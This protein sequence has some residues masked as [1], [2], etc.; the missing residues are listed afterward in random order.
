MVTLITAPKISQAQA[1]TEKAATEKTDAT[2]PEE[3]TGETTGG[4]K[5]VVDKN[6]K[7][8]D[9]ENSLVMAIKDGKVIIELRPD[10]APK[11]VARIKELTREG[12]YDGIVFHRVIESFMAQTGDPTGTGRGGSGKNLKAEFSSEKHVRGTLSMARAND[13]DSADSQ[14]FIVFQEAPHLDENYTVFGKVTEGMEFIDKIKKGYGPNGMVSE[15][16]KIISLKVAADIEYSDL[17]ES[18]KGSTTPDA[19]KTAGEQPVD[20]NLVGEKTETKT[21]PDGSI[22][23]IKTTIKKEE[24]QEAEKAQGTKELAPKTI[25][26][27]SGKPAS[28]Q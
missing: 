14:F 9:L 28:Q 15:P 24:L 8:K 18:L 25:D 27:N 1:E 11:H 5:P 7:P 19:N 12:F 6:A 17:P 10:L 22:E 13:P 16:D 23:V 26:P 4:D 2:K 20:P 21:N 3:K